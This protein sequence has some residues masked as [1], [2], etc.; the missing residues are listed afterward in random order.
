MLILYYHLNH[1][2]FYKKK[3]ADLTF[4]LIWT[5]TS[6]KIYFLEFFYFTIFKN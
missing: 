6:D 4:F 1:T 2:V 5:K 3:K